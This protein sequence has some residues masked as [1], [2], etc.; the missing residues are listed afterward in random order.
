[1]K[2]AVIF[3]LFAVVAIM[4]KAQNAQQILSQADSLRETGNYAEAIALLRNNENI[5]AQT[6]QLAN[7]YGSLSW[8][9][10][11]T[12][13]H[14]LSEQAAYK[15]LEID[16]TFT[17]VK[18]NLGHALLFQG[19]T[20]EAE[21]IYGELINESE[22]YTA[23][24][25][26]DFDQFE[27]AGI[28]PQNAKNDFERIKT[29]IN[30]ELTELIKVLYQL[31]N[32]HNADKYD[33]TIS[34]LKPYLSNL[35]EQ[36]A[37][38]AAN[39]IDNKGEECQDA[40]DYVK[41]EK[42]YLKAKAIRDKVLDKIY[43]DN[44]NSL[45][46]L[47]FLY[48]AMGDYAKAEKFHL[49]ALT[50]VENT[51][52]KEHTDYANI[53]SNLG[54]IYRA[55]G[56]YAQAEKCYLGAL[57]IREK[58]LGKEHPDYATS[59]DNLGG[60]YYSIGDY[61]KAKKY[62]LETKTTVENILGKE[63]PDYAY[64]LN[65]LGILYS[66][67]GDYPQAEKYYLEALNIRG[68]VLGKENPDYATS[69][70]NLGVLYGTMGDYAQAEKFQSE[71]L[72]I[73][74]KVLG[75][76]HPDYAISLGNLG[77]LYGTMGDYEQ[78]EKF[79]VEALGIFEKNFGKEHPNYAT[80]LMSLGNL[81]QTMG[82]YAKAEKYL[83]EALAIREKVL[84]KDHPDYATS[85]MSLGN[86][87][88]AMGDYAKAEKFYVEALTIK[89]KALGKEHPDYAQ[90]L[91]NLGNLYSNMCDYPKAEFFILELKNIQEKIL[92][93]EHPDYATSLNSLGF[94]Y[95][96]MGDYPKAE[97]YLLEAS[98]IREKVLG[99]EHSDY[100]QS[101]N[102][103]GL[104]CQAM[105]DYVNAEKYFLETENILEK[106]SDKE[107]PDYATF[108]SNV[109]N[110][111]TAMGDYH[112]AEK[113]HLEALTIQEKVLGKEHPS[114]ATS[115]NNLG[116]LYNNVGDYAKT[117]KYFLE[118]KNILGKVLGKEHPD[119]ATSLSNL[120]NLYT[121]VGDYPQAE[122]YFSE[123]LTIFEKVFGKEHPN[124]ALSLNNLGSLYQAMG[125][126]RKA[127]KCFLETLTIQEKALGKE[128]PDY[129]YSLNNLAIM[130]DAIGDYAQA[131]KYLLEA[132]NIFEKV[133]GKEHPNYA[134][135][136]NN[137]GT[138]YTT[139]GDYDKAEKYLLEALAIREKTLGKEHSDYAMSLS[140]LGLAYYAMGDYA[141]AEKYFS[142][143][144]SIWKKVLGEEHPYY[145]LSVS[146]MK[147][148]YQG[149]KEYEKAATLNNEVCG[150]LTK[151]VDKN[152]AFLSEQQRDQ[153]WKTKENEFTG[154]YSL[155]WFYP[156]SSVN[157]LNY[158]NTLFTKGLLLRTTNGI[159]DAV[160]SSENRSLINNFE[161]LGDLRQQ[162]S[163]LQQKDN[164]NKESVHTLE[165]RA[166]SLDKA[167]TQASQAYRD[168]KADMSMTW[169]DVQKQLTPT[170]A[171]VEFVSFRLIG[172]TGWT[173]STMYAAL[174]LR[175][176]M[177][178]PAW[179][180]LCEQKQL[181][182]LFQSAVN[183]TTRMQTEN[184]Y[185]KEGKNLYQL[186]W[187]A[188]EKELPNV[189]TVYYSPAGLL[190]KISFD[191]LPTDKEGMLLSDK[192][193]LQLV[194]STREIAR[195]KKETAAFV[196]DSTVVYGGLTYDRQQ[197]AYHESEKQSSGTDDIPYWKR[198][199]GA[200]L[201]AA[202]LR[203][204]FEAWKYLA[205]T[206]A[207]TEQIVS[208]LKSKHIPSQYYT[209]DKGTEESF[210]QLSSTKT[211]V[212]LLSTHGF[213]LP[214]I[215]N[216][217]VEDLVQHLGGGKEKPFENPLLRSGLILSGANDQWLDKEV[218]QD[219]RED[220]ILTADEIARLNL[221][222]TRLV[223]MSAC[224]TGLGDVKNSEGV[225]GLQ[226]AFKLA[227]VES[228]IMSL[229]KVPDD[230]TSELMSTFY[231]EW[232]SGQTKQNA[233][234][235]AQQKVREK[236]KSPYYWAAFVMMD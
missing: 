53:S 63:D 167:I 79:Q 182:T 216:K 218:I 96:K 178:A 154:S 72:V 92:G 144:L 122:K 58:V 50:I 54:D 73:R 13:E 57:A 174:V 210:K 10:L 220:G 194:S 81:Y 199:R 33:E 137:L 7:M 67:M 165:N 148:L 179:I 134:L 187:Q 40:G 173:D 195:L 185:I 27:R 200:E 46:R 228:L 184:I 69:L 51:L 77:N 1:M 76:N 9:Y 230:A 4:A 215:E 186:L 235:T 169:Q 160:Y 34:L 5:L 109:G 25:L 133:F 49:E 16:S 161:R 219:D 8:Y 85:L 198:H 45:G 206:K 66:T 3:I 41:A 135:S 35:S 117:E 93:K 17:F 224:E 119:Y 150:L 196:Q 223:V 94:L 19:K 140:N 28:I 193:D 32:L 147:F 115:L 120:G 75:K 29:A 23:A 132:K 212:I 222:K 20:A 168:L 129:A 191:A 111:Y 98:T 14:K 104:V 146:N 142:E 233:F 236:Y 42:C 107:R 163:S 97:K 80:S 124:Y 207:E 151:L 156:V 203:S 44:I 189:K 22:L 18:T 113:Y 36:Q 52:G 56:N 55:M 47:G 145:A 105:G 141:K 2:K 136:L 60:L 116:N 183:D 101:L 131:E 6:N 82:D 231:Q 127:E 108:L 157:G 99:K 62:Y 188:V 103:L 201:P 227:G 158:N 211:G 202:N 226:R 143:A 88:N 37:Q 121:T 152:F 221:T 68:K 234:K 123:A 180:P 190:Y 114:Y 100:A 204:G 112:K 213:F 139:M 78:A 171:A 15:T 21:K 125:D 31:S 83:L 205:G 24:L 176:G 138:L 87:Y 11:F 39:I 164:Y 102:N 153:Y 126:Y 166:D 229:W 90:S 225:F 61:A 162:I 48:Q 149:M 43:P 110:L 30:S 64:S 232:L 209:D 128:H 214:D 130:Y 118:T 70:H 159:R 197:L 74:E 86:L 106:V 38:L 12:K 181:D 95:Y 170:E 172:K 175:P 192:Y 59:L 65:S 177:E 91:N 89:E 71:A 208:L 26:D 217:A 84:G 155:S